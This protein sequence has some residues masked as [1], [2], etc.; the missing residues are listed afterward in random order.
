MKQRT[1]K[2]SLTSTSKGTRHNA[3]MAS[4]LTSMTRKILRK[5]RNDLLRG[6]LVVLAMADSEADMLSLPGEQREATAKDGNCIRQLTT[7]VELI[8]R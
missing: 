6:K 7:G 2:C 3:K 8:R 5:Q 4:M 1:G